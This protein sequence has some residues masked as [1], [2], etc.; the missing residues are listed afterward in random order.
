MTQRTALDDNEN[1][2]IWVVTAN[3]KPTAP[4]NKSVE[5]DVCVVGAGIAG[6]T[7]AFSW[8]V[9]ANPLWCWTSVPSIVDQSRSRN[10]RAAASRATNPLHSRGIVG[11]AL[12]GP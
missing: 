1:R 9:K 7:A 5:T 4:L 6:M 10:L 8:S 12:I 11:V 2:S 3:R